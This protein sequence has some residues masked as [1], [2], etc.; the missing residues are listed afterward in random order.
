[1]STDIAYK[2]VIDARDSQ[3]VKA[4]DEFKSACLDS[5]S[6]LLKNK[7][8]LPSTVDIDNDLE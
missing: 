4:Y 1:M 5:E 2:K 8:S 3:I 6:S 7:S